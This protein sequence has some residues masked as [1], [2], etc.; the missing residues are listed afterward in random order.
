[1][2]SPVVGM[3]IHFAGIALLSF[4]VAGLL[5]PAGKGATTIFVVGNTVGTICFA[6]VYF[7]MYGANWTKL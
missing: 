2:A 7:G 5:D 3:A 1:M 6:G 4:G